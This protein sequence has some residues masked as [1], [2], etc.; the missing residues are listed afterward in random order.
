MQHKYKFPQQIVSLWTFQS[1]YRIS[2][3]KTYTYY[4]DD[5]FK[6]QTNEL[7]DQ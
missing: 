7:S 4:N 1:Q 2:Q 6:Q 5:P 3:H